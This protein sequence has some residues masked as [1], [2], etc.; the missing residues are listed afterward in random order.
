MDK[1]IEHTKGVITLDNKIKGKSYIIDFLRFI[2]AALVIFSHA[3]AV[4]NSGDDW[5]F[6]VSR[7]GITFGELSVAF[8][9]FVSGLYV[10]KSLL[11]KRNVRGWIRSRCSCRR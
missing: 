1:Q 8:F 6:A 5:L 2:A 9:L 3:Y 4:T 10:T 7:H 11:T